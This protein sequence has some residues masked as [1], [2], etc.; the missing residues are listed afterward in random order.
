M[1]VVHTHSVVCRDDLLFEVELDAAV[2][3]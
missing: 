3:A 2:T 1:P